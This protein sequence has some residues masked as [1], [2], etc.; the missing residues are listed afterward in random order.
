M[1][2]AIHSHYSNWNWTKKLRGEVFYPRETQCQLESATSVIN[3]TNR[4]HNALLVWNW[5]F[6]SISKQRRLLHRVWFCP[7]SAQ[8]LNTFFPADLLFYARFVL[9]AV[10]HMIHLFF[11]FIGADGEQLKSFANS[12]EF[13]S[14]PMTRNLSVAWLSLI[15]FLRSSSGKNEKKIFC[16]IFFQIRRD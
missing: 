4:F 5:F 14:G 3:V 6:F 1:D 13:E 12:G 8:L 2:V 10:H 7:N 11:R 16:N 15:T 9:C